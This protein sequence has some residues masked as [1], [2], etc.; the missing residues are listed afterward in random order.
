MMKQ[1]KR[2]FMGAVLASVFAAAPAL[3]HEEHS[4]GAADHANLTDDRKALKLEPS[5]RAMLLIEMRQ[6]LNGIQVMTESLSRDDLKAVANAAK[7]LGRAAMH[8]VPDSMKAKLPKEF[9]QFALAVHG[10]FDQIAMDAESLGDTKHTQKQVADLL[11]NCVSCHN[12]FQ[13][14]VLPEK[15]Q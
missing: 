9:K 4:H 3:A 7:P 6:F 5:E 11:K 13:I 15:K 8:E 10:G 12:T 1:G 14:Q 2:L